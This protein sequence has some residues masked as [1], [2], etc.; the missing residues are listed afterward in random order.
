MEGLQAQVGEAR[1]AL[2]GALDYVLADVRQKW[3]EIS[4]GPSVTDGLRQFVAAVDWSVRGGWQPVGVAGSQSCSACGRPA[5]G[6]GQGAAGSGPAGRPAAARR[7]RPQPP[8]TAAR[9]P[10]ERWIQGLLAFHIG[11]LICVI[12]LRRL[13][14]FH[15]A[16]FLGI[17]ERRWG[18]WGGA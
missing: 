5:A 15:G 1:D 6:G 3:A 14:L 16:V 10:Q 2:A 7:R 13:P 9:R 11:L 12:A 18:C 17:S 8:P 4:G